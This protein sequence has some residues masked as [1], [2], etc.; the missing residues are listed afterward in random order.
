ME[1]DKQQLSWASGLALDGIQ[2][3]SACLERHVFS[4]ENGQQ[5]SSVIMCVND[6]TDI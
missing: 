3:S 1:L 6:E 2:I 5:G 4:Q